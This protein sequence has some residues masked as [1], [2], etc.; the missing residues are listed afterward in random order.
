MD[1]HHVAAILEEI[2]VLLELQGANPFR[3]RAYHNAARSIESVDDLEKF[4][5]E[6]P[7]DSLP[8]IGKDLAE[9]IGTLLETGRLPYFEELKKSFPEGVLELL[10]VP[11]LGAKKI[12]ILYEKLRIESV[13]DLAKAIAADK[14]ATLKGFGK[15]SQENLSNALSKY[16]TY[17]KRVLWWHGMREALQIEE[18]LAKHKDVELVE[19]AGSL[20]RKL[21][22]VGDFD[23]VVA[24]KNPK[25]LIDW[26]SKQFWVASVTSKGE[27]KC[28]VRLKTGLQADLR[29]VPKEQFAFALMY[30]TGSKDHSI[31]IRKIANEQGLTLNEYGLQTIKKPV[32]KKKCASEEEIY[33]TLK[34]EYIPPE[35]REDRGEI[36]LAIQHKLPKLIEDDDIRGVFHCHTTD[37]DG[38]DTLE[39]MAGAAADLGWE[40][41]GISD[42][43]KASYQAG[44]MHE[45]QLEAQVKKIRAFNKS[46]KSSVTLLAGLECDILADGTLDFADETLKKLDFVIVSIHRRYKLDASLATKRLIKAIENPYTTIVGHMTGRL[47]LR[48]E[49]VALNIPK[50]IDACIANNKVVEINGFPDRLDMDWRHWQKAKEKGLKCA[51][52]PDA[53]RKE[54]LEFFRTGINIARKGWLEK[55]DVINTF[56]KK[57]LLSFLDKVRG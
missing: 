42:H 10:H 16:K 11:G 35:L 39:E 28:S 3:I 9:K 31:H 13:D 12:K 2:G 4:A 47:L 8:G 18:G 14:I 54:Q 19:I 46:K 41:L 27:T 36:A 34:M 37:S 15:K 43:S 49:P 30:S 6:N 52:N 44:G 40:Y 48:R 20:R 7:L 51:I 1:K 53:H 55:E 50:V 17:G 24:S 32:R 21:E 26:F 29:V 38:H 33:E 56:S 23:F 25:R 22:T 5:K 45:E 57:K